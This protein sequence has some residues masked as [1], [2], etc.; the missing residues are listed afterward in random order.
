MVA[1]DFISTDESKRTMDNVLGL[2]KFF[3][4]VPSKLWKR[5]KTHI[6]SSG[7]VAF[8]GDKKCFKAGVMLGPRGIV[9]IDN[10]CI[11]YLYLLLVWIET[12]VIRSSLQLYL[13]SS[14]LQL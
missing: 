12:I 6:G 11:P 9:V 1:L 5:R 2:Q 4:I 14:S 8:L 7:R 10:G 3:K 13:E